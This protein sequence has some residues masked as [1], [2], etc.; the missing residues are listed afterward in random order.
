[1]RACQ[2]RYWL[3]YLYGSVFAENWPSV[4]GC[5]D[6]VFSSN[7]GVFMKLV[8]FNINLMALTTKTMR[9]STPDY[10]THLVSTL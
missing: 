2:S 10:Q 6:D 3:Q 1:M 8:P 4:G 9:Q 5:D 7:D